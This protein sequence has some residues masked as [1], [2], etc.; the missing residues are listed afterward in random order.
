MSLTG[1]DNA[2]RVLVIGWFSFDSMGST[3]GD[4]IA[5]DVAAGWLR[6][7]GLEPV[8]AAHRPD[9]P[10][11]VPTG[12]VKPEAFGT[13]VFV[14]GPIG[15]GPPI[16]AFLDRFQ[17]ARKF[18]LDVTLLQS[19]EEWWPFDH[20]VERDGHQRVNADITF[21][22]PRY[23][24]PVVGVVLVGSQAEYPSNRHDHV[25]AVFADL[26]TER[27]A[28]AV[29][30]DTR[31]DVNAAGLRS[32]AQVESLIARMD[33]IL[34]TRLH[35]AALALRRGVP[36]VVV[37]SVPG[38]SKVLAQMRHIGWPLSFDVADL[39]PA[40]LAHAL[41]IALGPEGRELVEATARRAVG[42]VAQVREEF[43]AAVTAS[44]LAPGR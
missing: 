20:V 40:A 22:A 11:Q 23:E 41:D 44:S 18:A 12:D 36:P 10:G 3:A 8:V 28:A 27:G 43:L 13:V 29:P 39:D 38:G 6:E 31:L 33:A 32:A 34:T 37:D 15:N 17:H 16:N 1:D 21:A 4:V 14:C 5:S 2:S 30:I 35:G 7:V 9:R 42:Q 26:I 24:A 25:E 19:A